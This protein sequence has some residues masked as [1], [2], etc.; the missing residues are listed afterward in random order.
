MGIF[1]LKLGSKCQLVGDDLFVVIIKNNM[2]INKKAGNSI[3]IKLNQIGSLTE[4]IETI[5]LAKKNNFN[6][7]ISIDQVKLKIHLFQISQLAHPLAKL[8]LVLYADLKE[9]QSIIN[10]SE[11]KMRR[12]N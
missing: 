6:T 4:T 3:L 12:F 8:K 10:Y 5:K 2:G 11:L 1:N 7:I 9:L